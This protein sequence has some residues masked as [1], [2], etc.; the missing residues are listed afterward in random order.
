[1][2]NSSKMWVLLVAILW[3]SLVGC[4]REE[5]VLHPAPRRIPEVQIKQNPIE[6]P[7]AE[8]KYVGPVVDTQDPIID[9]KARA[10]SAE[11]KLEDWKCEEPSPNFVDYRDS[12]IDECMKHEIVP[13]PGDLTTE[14]GVIAALHQAET[15]WRMCLAP[16]SAYR[17]FAATNNAAEV[18]NRFPKG[19]AYGLEKTW[20]KRMDVARHYLKVAHS[21]VVHG[22]EDL[23]VF[24]PAC[25]RSHSI[26]GLQSRASL[27]SEILYLSDVEHIALEEIASGL[28]KNALEQK[29]KAGVKDLMESWEVAM[30]DET[31]SSKTAFAEHLCDDL[32]TELDTEQVALLGCDLGEPAEEGTDGG[33]ASDGTSDKEM[34]FAPENAD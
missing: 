23:V 21:Y 31:D 10:L 24:Q 1:M 25:S 22:P 13:L 5:Q 11:K 28:T 29:I 4:N 30:D 18:A 32:S 33:E 19:T 7:P 16:I 8:I 26:C 27:A 20:A 34:K 3:S 14:D 15:A 6:L 17:D 9:W 12:E 2:R